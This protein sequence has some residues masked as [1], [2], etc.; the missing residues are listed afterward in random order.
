[1]TSVFWDSQGVLFIDFLREQRTINT[2]YY[3]KLLK[4]EKSQPFIQKD[5]VDQQKASVSCHTTA[6]P[7][8]TTVTTRTLEEMHW[9][10]LPHPAYSR[11]LAESD[12]HLFGPL[13]G[14]L[15]GKGFRADDEVKI[16]V[17]R[18]LGIQPQMLLK[19]A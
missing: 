4:D 14:A 16:F 3:T 12:F 7:H 8:T 19:G 6:R 17:S 18:W 15:G 11:D 2:S 1:M 10:V 9:E 5:G 13:K